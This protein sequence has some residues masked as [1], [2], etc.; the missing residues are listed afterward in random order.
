ER[1][2]YVELTPE[3]ERLAESVEKKHKMLNKFLTE[4]LKID[5]KTAAEDA[6]KM[7]HSIS[8]ETSKKLTK[9]IEFVETCPDHDRP[10][11]LKSF[12]YYFKTGK[13]LRCKVRQIKQKVKH[14]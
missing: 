11:W 5:P 2:G 3:G 14:E 12:D 4:V 13:R 7:E 1:Y 10:D 6:C 9:F 8:P